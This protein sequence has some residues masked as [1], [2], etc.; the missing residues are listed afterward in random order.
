MSAFELMTL[1]LALWGAIL[2]TILGLNELWS[3]RKKLKVKNEIF[4]DTLT[5]EGLEAFYTLS[6]VNI[7]E[8][9][10][11]LQNF[12]LLLP[13]KEKFC[14]ND[15]SSKPVNLPMNLSDGENIS[16]DANG[17]QLKWLFEAAN[18]HKHFDSTGTFKIRGFFTDTSGRI[19]KA[20]KVTI[21][22]DRLYKPTPM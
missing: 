15:N 10:I 8:R 14:F 22:I 7:G 16:I 4:Y 5:G 18:M 11:R 13:N 17:K 3:R 21:D 1:T 2:S 6:C 20:R 19:Y 9:I 12:G